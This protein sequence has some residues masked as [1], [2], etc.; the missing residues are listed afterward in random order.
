MISGKCRMIMT[1]LLPNLSQENLMAIKRVCDLC[2]NPATKVG[3]DK[4]ST[5]TFISLAT[6]VEYKMKFQVWRDV[7]GKVETTDLCLKCASA[8]LLTGK[9]EE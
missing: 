5:A 8:A 6:K 3:D 2:A 9:S 1:Q 4:S 7:D